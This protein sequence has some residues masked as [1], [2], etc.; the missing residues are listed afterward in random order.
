MHRDDDLTFAPLFMLVLVKAAAALSQ[1]LP[2]C[3]AFHYLAPHLSVGDLTK[4]YR[5]E[6]LHFAF[7]GCVATIP[8]SL[9]F[10]LI[11]I[12]Y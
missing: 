5:I 6:F 1:P 2:K 3:G 4:H 7:T 8:Q 12:K 9:R 10:P 11:C